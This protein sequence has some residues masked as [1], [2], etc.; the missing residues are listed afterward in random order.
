MV[1]TC[2]LDHYISGNWQHFP[3]VNTE[4]TITGRRKLP[5]QASLE[6]GLTP[7]SHGGWACTLHPAQQ[8]AKGLAGKSGHG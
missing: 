7:G 1:A 8:P 5:R 6:G 4:R 3:A 2:R